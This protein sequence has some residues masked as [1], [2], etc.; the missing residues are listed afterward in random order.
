MA[1]CSVNSPVTSLSHVCD[2]TVSGARA[3]YMCVP[4][5][6]CTSLRE[7]R[8]RY[9][10][11]ELLSLSRPCVCSSDVFTRLA[12]LNILSTDS[13]SYQRHRRRRKRPYRGGRRK[14]GRAI[15]VRVTQRNDYHLHPPHALPVLDYDADFTP[16]SSSY[17]Y[18]LLGRAPIPTSSD[19]GG[20]AVPSEMFSPRTEHDPSPLP[21]SFY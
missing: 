8:Y 15:P 6:V 5:R 12:D 1:Q 21:S 9:T 11:A 19:N 17:G 16:S 2:W 13:S 20:S 14:R 10:K 7:P 18:W 4:A 3:P